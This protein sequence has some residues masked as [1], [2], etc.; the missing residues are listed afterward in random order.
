[1]CLTLLSPG[2][3]ADELRNILL[4]RS[5]I[6]TAGENCNLK[7]K[8]ESDAQRDEYSEYI[9]A[10][11]KDMKSREVKS[12]VSDSLLKKFRLNNTKV[13]ADKS[14]NLDQAAKKMADLFKVELDVAHEMSDDESD[15]VSD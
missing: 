13:L 3:E 8:K 10:A 5:T 2:P 1:M 15:E 11:K 9:E 12:F 6:T 7:R 4:V 14:L